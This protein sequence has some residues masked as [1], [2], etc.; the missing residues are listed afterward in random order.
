LLVLQ[1]KHVIQ[2]QLRNMVTIHSTIC[3]ALAMFSLTL[4][5]RYDYPEA[6]M[7]SQSDMEKE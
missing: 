4:H 2:E 6:S 5:L 1:E 3:L 7:H